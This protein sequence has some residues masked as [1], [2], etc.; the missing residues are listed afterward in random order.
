MPYAAQHL[1][2]RWGGFFGAD[3]ATQKDIW[4]CGVRIFLGASPLTEEKKTAF[5]TAVAPAL[6]TWWNANATQGHPSAWQSEINCAYIDLD[7]KY[8]GGDEQPTT[9]LPMTPPVAGKG[10]LT[11]AW[12]T[13]MVVTLSSDI[14]RGRGSRG[15]YY[16]PTGMG[17]DA[18]GV[19]PQG[20]LSAFVL[21]QRT[22]ID[23]LNTAARAQWSPAAGVSVFSQLGAGTIGE[24]VR[25]GSDVAPDT[26]R[27]RDNKLVE[28]RTEINLT[29]AAAARAAIQDR[30]YA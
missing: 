11:H 12:S 18:N 10:G 25:V 23:A 24:V 14:D 3:A 16:V 6:A 13:A 20:N 27:R 30:V 17:I 15:R 22:L 7:G 26:Q 4:S 21:A 1:L 8:V 2:F 9:R 29:T 5:L 28:P 19:F